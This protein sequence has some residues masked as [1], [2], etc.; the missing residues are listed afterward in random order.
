M[1]RNNNYPPAINHGS[2]Q[3]VM[4]DS[5]RVINSRSNQTQKMQSTS[6]W[7]E[8]N[9]SISSIWL[10]QH[11]PGEK[12]PRSGPPD[13][14]SGPTTSSHIAGAASL[15]AIKYKEFSGSCISFQP[16]SRVPGIFVH[17]HDHS[18][19]APTLGTYILP[20]LGSTFH[21][22]S[23]L[24]FNAD[25]LGLLTWRWMSENLETSGKRPPMMTVKIMKKN[26][27][28]F[29]IFRGYRCPFDT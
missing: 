23:K 4:F 26:N 29:Q 8:S 5:G 16:W 21:P 9:R 19:P 27:G 20:K 17:F 7:Q 18:L 11:G 6:H 14:C 28:D 25:S 15:K 12:S 13:L 24:K 2:G 22:A 10:V 3:L 1:E